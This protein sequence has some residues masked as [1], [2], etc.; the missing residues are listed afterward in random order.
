[1]LE[2]NL[3]DEQEFTG[4]NLEMNYNVWEGSDLGSRTTNS[5]VVNSRVCS[6]EN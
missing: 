5:G 2:L 4:Q 1:M 3:S 6:G